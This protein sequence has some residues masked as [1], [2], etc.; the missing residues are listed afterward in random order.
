M[1]QK[2]EDLGHG[3]LY[4]FKSGDYRVMG[5]DSKPPKWKEG[6]STLWNQRVYGSNSFNSNIINWFYYDGEWRILTNDD[7]FNPT[8]LRLHRLYVEELN[9]CRL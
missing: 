4:G 5:G 9:K 6:M 3:Q 8:N 1:N 7:I 2:N